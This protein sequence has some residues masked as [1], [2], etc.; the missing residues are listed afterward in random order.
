MVDCWGAVEK[1]PHN[2][3]DAVGGPD[4]W[5]HVVWALLHEMCHEN[6]MQKNRL[7]VLKHTGHACCVHTT[8]LLL[9]ST[10][11]SACLQQHQLV[12]R[13]L[14]SDVHVCVSC[15]IHVCFLSI[16]VCVCWDA[17][18]CFARHNMGFCDVCGVVYAQGLV[19]LCIHRHPHTDKAP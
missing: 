5:G 8:L 12:L 7:C 17:Y 2:A 11:V 16:H 15:G 14:H 3:A 10:Y 13:C 19:L 6:V 1:P 9:T 4:V 18:V